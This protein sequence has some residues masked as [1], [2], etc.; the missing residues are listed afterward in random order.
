MKRHPATKP[1]SA[2]TLL[3]GVILSSYTQAQ[4]T[5]QI[6]LKTSHQSSINQVKST[7]MEDQAAQTVKT[8]LKAV[9]QGDQATLGAL[10]HPD[11]KWNQPGTNRFSGVK[12]TSTDVF[13]MVGNMFAATANTLQLTDVKQLTVNG[14]KVACLIHWKGAQPGGG[15]LDVDNIDVYTVEN[16]KIVEATIYSEDIKQEDYFWG[17]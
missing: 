2:I 13:Q 17:K 1:L 15:V 6:S 8:F 12:K 10:V 14:N 7:T 3:L 16:G 11:I 4:T 9:Q 5:N